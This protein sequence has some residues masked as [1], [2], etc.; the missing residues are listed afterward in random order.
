MLNLDSHTEILQIIF[1]SNIKIIRCFKFGEEELNFIQRL[2]FLLEKLFALKLRTSELNELS[3]KNYAS[4][5]E[6]QKELEDI[7][8]TS[9]RFGR[10]QIGASIKDLRRMLKSN[11]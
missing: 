2:T 6:L 5:L 9:K 7:N 1:Y 4:M 8:E 11:W 10:K 3:D